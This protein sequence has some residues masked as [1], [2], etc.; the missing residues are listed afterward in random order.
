MGVVVLIKKIKIM[1]SSFFWCLKCWFYH[2]SASAC[3]CVVAILFSC[4]YLFC[5]CLHNTSGALISLI[6]SRKGS[7][8]FFLVELLLDSL[9]TFDAFDP[10]PCFLHRNWSFM[11]IGIFVVVYFGFLFVVVPFWIFATSFL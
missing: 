4:C 8:C 10:L 7:C 6:G 9:I 1:L 2:T 11:T 3:C 5:L